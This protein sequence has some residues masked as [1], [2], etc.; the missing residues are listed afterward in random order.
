MRERNRG[1]K[2]GL[3]FDGGRTFALAI[4]ERAAALAV[5]A[6]RANARTH[7]YSGGVLKLYPSL[8]AKRS[9]PE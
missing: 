2:L 6:T 3:S 7:F 9:N 1:P 4:A 5:A 8:R